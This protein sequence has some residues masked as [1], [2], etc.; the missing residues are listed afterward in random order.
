MLMLL[1][2]I[3]RSAGVGQRHDLRWADRPTARRPKVSVVGV[4]VA[5]AGVAAVAP[6]PLNADRLG[7]HRINDVQHRCLGTCA[8]RLERHAD[9]ATRACAR[10]VPQVLVWVNTNGLAPPIVMLLIASADPPVLVSVTACA[11]LIDQ[12]ASVPKASVLGV[13]VAVAASQQSPRTAQADRLGTHRIN[14]VQHRRLGTCAVRL[15]RHV[16]RA[17]RACARLVPQ[18]LVW[19][20]SYVVPLIEMLLTQRRSACWSASRL[21]GL[22]V[23][24]AVRTSA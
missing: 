2:G 1:I 15:E 9:R 13:T 11:G 18:L 23:S 5:V 22:V 16:D 19:A 14:D 8:V 24:P 20:N 21:R 7:S 17:T 4:S 3:A 6:V 12:T 10:L